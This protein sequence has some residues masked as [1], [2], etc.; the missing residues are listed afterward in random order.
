MRQD[1]WRIVERLLDQ[2]QG[3][4]GR[5][6]LAVAPQPLDIVLYEMPVLARR[7]PPQNPLRGFIQDAVSL[8]GEPT[9]A[10]IASLFHLPSTVV[11]LVLGNLQQIGSVTSDVAGRW[12]VPKGA[13]IFKS[14]GGDPPIW[15]RTRHLLCY[16]PE[17]DVMLPVLP[18]L[19]L[20]DLVELGVHTLQ[21]EVKDWYARCV[22]WSGAEGTRRGLPD[23]IRLLP[24]A[25]FTSAEKGT[26]GVPAVLADAPIS[27]EEVLVSRCQLDVIALT[28]ASPRCGVWEVV[29]R[30]W[31]RPTPSDES[32][33]E[34][35]SP[36]EPVL[37]LSLPEHLLGGGNRLNELGTLFDPQTDLWRS[38]LKEQDE[39][40]RPH[41]DLDGD[42]PSVIVMHSD[43]AEEKLR[44]RG[45]ATHLAPE[46]RLLCSTLS[47][48]RPGAEDRREGKRQ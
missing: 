24:L 42:S 43:K 3:T 12:S 9:A 17:R 25:D 29:S 26:S 23:T 38:L 28:W 27:G 46:A 4:A 5:L 18:R 2:I 47:A 45:L 21:S 11:E 22:A 15:R 16:W 44:W 40:F 31:S 14:G 20:R 1:R 37:G 33:G 13:P 41:R 10:E 30:I 35:F 7:Q 36:S 39:Q 6:V 8:L 34:P 48:A 19:R 32:D